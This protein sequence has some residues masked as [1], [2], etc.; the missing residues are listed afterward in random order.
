MEPIFLI[1]APRSGTTW[2]QLMLSQSPFIATCQ[3][4]QLFSMHYGSLFESIRAQT[5]RNGRQVG[6]ANILGHE[7]A[8]ELACRQVREALAEVV[9]VSSKPDAQVFL[10]KTPQHV[11]H[12]ELIRAVFPKARFLELVRDPRAVVASLRAVDW[13]DWTRSGTVLNAEKWRAA[14]RAGHEARGRIPADDYRIIKYEELQHDPATR[15]QELLEWIGDFEHA[16]AAQSYTQACDITAL[17]EGTGPQAAWDLQSEPVSFFRYGKVDSWKTE[18]TRHQTRVVEQ[19]CRE[20]MSMHGYERRFKASRWACL[21]V[22]CYWQLR[23]VTWRVSKLAN[24][25]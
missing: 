10:E 18:L 3:E 22:W 2:L 4:T 17:R 14:I 5:H 1:G 19:V 25:I 6:L 7:E 16:D 13:G 24:S 21:R 9:R 15:L 12:I 8:F 11:A 23:A 20:G